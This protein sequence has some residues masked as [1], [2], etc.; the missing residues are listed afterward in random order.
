MASRAVVPSREITGRGAGVAVLGGS[1]FSRARTV[2]IRARS[3]AVR[4]DGRRNTTIAVSCSPERK[5]FVS[6]FAF[7]DSALPGRKLEGSFF[8]ASSNLL[9][10]TKANAKITTHP[11][12]NSHLLRRPLAAVRTRRSIGGSLRRSRAAVQ[13]ERDSRTRAPRP[14]D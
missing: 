13:A 6:S 3:A 9:A 11:N 12:R 7:S 4:P 1:A 8:C 2:A 5:S 10:G 14:S